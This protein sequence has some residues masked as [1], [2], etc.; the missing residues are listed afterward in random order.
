MKFITVRD[1]RTSPAQVWKELPEDYPVPSMNEPFEN[2][3]IIGGG[4][5]E[6]CIQLT[7]GRSGYGESAAAAAYSID[8]WR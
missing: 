7:G 4:E 2:C 6:A 8:A 3:I 1:I 5:E